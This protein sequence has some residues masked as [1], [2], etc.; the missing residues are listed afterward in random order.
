V[1]ENGALAPASNETL[2]YLCIDFAVTS[3]NG[4]P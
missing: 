4:D 1:K 2:D 3:H